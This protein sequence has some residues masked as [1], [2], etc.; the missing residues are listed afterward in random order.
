VAQSLLNKIICLVSGK[1]RRVIGPPGSAS[2]RRA[3]LEES[4]SQRSSTNAGIA[5]RDRRRGEGSV[6]ATPDR[7]SEGSPAESRTGP[8]KSSATDKSGL[9]K[10]FGPVGDAT[11]ANLPIPADLREHSDINAKE[12]SACVRSVAI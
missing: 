5:P 2:Y 11:A 4:R 7:P 6:T 12:T 1:K 8:S 9:R 10:V 3:A